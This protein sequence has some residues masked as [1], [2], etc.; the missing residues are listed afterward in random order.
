MTNYVTRFF[1][2]FLCCIV[3]PFYVLLFFLVLSD[4]IF[5]ARGVATVRHFRHVPTH[6]FP[7]KF[8]YW[9]KMTNNA[10]HIFNYVCFMFIVLV[11]SFHKLKDKHLQ[12]VLWPWQFILSSKALSWH[13]IKH[14]LFFTR[15]LTSESRNELIH[16]LVCHW[17]SKDLLSGYWLAV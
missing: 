1:F 12:W 5:P 9:W 4:I 14:N 2:F 17:T 16:L 8:V 3:F 11:T 7:P 13:K 6:N 15:F 10:L